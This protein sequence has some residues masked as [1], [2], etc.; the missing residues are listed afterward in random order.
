MSDLKAE[1]AARR[2]KILAREKDRLL[3]AKGE[4]TFESNP[5]DSS[6]VSVDADAVKEDS[7][8]VAKERPLA[9]RRN[10]VTPTKPNAD[11]NNNI[12][13]ENK[14]SND[15]SLDNS[16]DDLKIPKKTIDDINAEV[17]KN[18]A[19]FDE[20]VLNNPNAL[21]AKKNEEK[22]ASKPTPAMTTS[23]F[24]SLVRLVLIVSIGST[25]GY[26][27]AISKETGIKLNY[28]DQNKANPIYNKLGLPDIDAK[29][30]VQFDNINTFENPMQYSVLGI[31]VIWIISMVLKSPLEKSVH[32]KT[33]LTKLII[34]KFTIYFF[35][36]H[37]L[38][39][40]I[41]TVV[42]F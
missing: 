4:K 41:R 23:T 31:T 19:K 10:R 5:L 37:S 33:Y 34:S 26:K 15:N 27:S 39:L 18:T 16:V 35:I 12:S 17:A 24:M 25:I 21:S 3:A 20:T 30:R 9:V 1:A 22:K 11:E 14:A 13:D 29:S 7:S 40:K 2:A 32:I 36:N 28:V 8:P 6:A 38:A 42:G